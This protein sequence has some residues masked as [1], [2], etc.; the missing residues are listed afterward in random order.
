[1]DHTADKKAGYM[2]FSV[3]YG[4]RAAAAFAFSMFLAALFLGKY[5][6]AAVP[7]FLAF[8]ALLFS[9][10]IL[11]PS[12]KL[13]S[14]FMLLVIAAIFIIAIVFFAGLPGIIEDFYAKRAHI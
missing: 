3:R 6:I 4:K 12:E 10:V 2:T 8:C 14:R 1:M 9:I 13:A 7:Y 5:E 11:R